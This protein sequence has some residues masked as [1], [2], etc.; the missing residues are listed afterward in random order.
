M[1][2]YLEDLQDLQDLRE[3]GLDAMGF[4]FVAYSCACCVILISGMALMP[5]IERLLHTCLEN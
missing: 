3:I 5:F 2:P 4:N 1:T